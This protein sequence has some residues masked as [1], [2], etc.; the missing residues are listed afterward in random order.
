MPHRLDRLPS[1]LLPGGVRVHVAASRRARTLGLAWLRAAPS[2]RALLLVRCRSVHTAG[3]RWP[4]DLVWLDGAGAVVR[5]DA[6]VRPRRLRACRRA[7]AVVEV[8]AGEAGALLAALVAEG[9]R[10]TT[11][12]GFRPVARGDGAGLGSVSHRCIT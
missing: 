12:L 7:R 11:D 2:G 9:R 6:G 10:T 1:V 8:P 5:V 4:L 3:M